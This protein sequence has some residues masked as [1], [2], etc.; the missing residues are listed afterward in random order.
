M[1]EVYVQAG[2]TRLTGG[3]V[4]D[5]Y[6]ECGSIVPSFD[7]WAYPSTPYGVNRWSQLRP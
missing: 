6:Y 7:F 3:F 5:T 4:G 1:D 2:F